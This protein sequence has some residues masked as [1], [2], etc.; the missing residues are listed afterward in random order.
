MEALPAWLTSLKNKYGK[1]R[2]LVHSAGQTLT[3]PLKMMDYAAAKNI[4]DIN[5]F[6]AL[7]LARGFSD[8]RVNSGNGSSL[9]FIASTA[10]H[11]PAR[12]LAAYAGSKA[13]LVTTAKALALEAAPQ[14]L[15]VN[16]ISPAFVDTPMA[17]AYWA[18]FGANPDPAAYPLG[19][20]RPEDVAALAVF[21]ASDG[22]RWITGQNYILDGGAGL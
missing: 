16:C 12:G 4:F 18:E 21:L 11:R 1:M 9:T 5:Y 17:R 2:G 20:G 6:V 7:L 3:R 22:A 19:L 13:A 8:R 10:A 14:S 15:R